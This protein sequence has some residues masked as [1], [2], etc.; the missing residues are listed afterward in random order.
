MEEGRGK[1]KGKKDAKRFDM[2]KHKKR[3]IALRFAYI[4]HKYQGLVTQENTTETVEHYLFEALKRC[5]LV[6]PGAPGAPENYSRCGRTDKGVSAL[7]QV[8]AL[9]VRTSVKEGIEFVP[10]GG[11]APEPPAAEA[12]KEE[13]EK[14]KEKEGEEEKEKGKEEEEVC[15]PVGE[16]EMDFPRVLNRLL[17]DDIR[18]T[19]WAP[20]PRNFSARFSCSGRVYKYFFVKGSLDIDIMRDAA[21]RLVG[22]HDFRNFA[23]MDVVN[24]SNF[25]RTIFSITI[26]PLTEGAEPHDPHTVWVVTVAGTA[27]LYHQ[28]RCMVAILFEVGGGR[29]SPDVITHLLNVESNPRRPSYKMA[30]EVGLVLW[31]CLFPTVRWHTTPAAHEQLL[32]HLLASYQSTLLLPSI[33]LGM[34]RHLSDSYKLSFLEGG[35]PSDPRTWN[36]KPRE[37]EGASPRNRTKLLDLPKEKSYEERVEGL[38]ATKRARLEENKAKNRPMQVFAKRAKLSEADLEAAKD[39]RDDTG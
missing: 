3:H 18:V 21:A 32:H 14:E 27:F 2:S 12:T 6:D 30:P 34:F 9:H 1:K 29:E 31:D 23:K 37:G 35:S 20:V 17:P 26:T 38:N 16:G 36:E 28:I 4:G 5:R 13:E 25:V 8:M 15:L 10:E 24:V 7:G 19:A 22:E 33:F 11:P 39:I